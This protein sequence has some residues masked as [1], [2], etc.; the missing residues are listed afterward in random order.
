[1]SKIIITVPKDSKKWKLSGVGT[2]NKS[3]ATP[4][5]LFNWLEKRFRVR[6]LREKMSVKV[7]YDYG[8]NES[9][10]SNN[11]SY[12]LYTLACFLKDYLSK[13]M[14]DIKYKK[15]KQNE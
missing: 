9:L 3:F 7:K 8:T 13:E 11:S 12:L 5:S 1:M 15:Y 6:S 4:A 14:L 2:R 10:L